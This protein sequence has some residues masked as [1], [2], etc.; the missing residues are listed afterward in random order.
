MT[1]KRFTTNGYYIYDTFHDGTKWLVNEVEA[2]EI[3]DKMNNLDLKA[4]ERSKALSKLQ[5]ENEQLRIL[6]NI[7]NT[8]AKDLVDVLNIQENNIWAL[9]KENGQ[10]KQSQASML[11]ELLIYRRIASCS[12]CKHQNYDWFEDGD[13]FEICEKGNGNQQI[14]YH[15]CEDWEEF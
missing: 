6:T 10:L 14:E 4:R 2:E 8:N 12:N 7:K 3:V 15:I 1:A 11:R 9:K 13:E 5:K